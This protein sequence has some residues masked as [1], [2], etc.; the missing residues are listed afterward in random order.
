[1][2]PK[3]SQHDFKTHEEKLFFHEKKVFFSKICDL[4]KSFSSLLN[5]ERTVLGKCDNV[6]NPNI[7]SK[8]FLAVAERFQNIMRTFLKHKRKNYFFMKNIFFKKIFISKFFQKSLIGGDFDFLDEFDSVWDPKK[9][10]KSFFKVLK[11]HQNNLRTILK[12]ERKN[13]FLMNFFFD[14]LNS[15]NFIFHK[16]C[17]KSS[18]IA[19]RS[20][21]KWS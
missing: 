15:K 17:S 9:H 3:H 21:F 20:N 6:C 5:W 19:I 16:F 2:I 18:E 11:W 10:Q 1:M 4:Q 13:D 12:F 14:F 8:S 7:C